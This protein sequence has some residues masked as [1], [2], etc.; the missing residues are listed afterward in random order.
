MTTLP[1][2]HSTLQAIPLNKRGSF[3]NINDWPSFKT[4]LIEE[5]GNIDIFGCEVNQ[6]LDLLPCYE[7]VQEVAEDL[8]PKIKTLQAKLEITK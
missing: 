1:N 2:L 3:D 8:A 4:R 7:S 6:I 5:F